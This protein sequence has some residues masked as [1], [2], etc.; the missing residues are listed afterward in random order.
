MFEGSIIGF[1]GIFREATTWK[2]AAFQMIAD[3]LAA[4]PL[5]WTTGVSTCAV[6]KVF[7]FVALHP[8]LLFEILSTS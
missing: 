6:F 5:L 2:L 3:A 4:Y 7:L 8:F 1:L